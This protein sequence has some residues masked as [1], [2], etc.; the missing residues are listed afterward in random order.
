MAI[1]SDYWHSIADA[2]IHEVGVANCV[3]GGNNDLL[4]FG[5]FV[6]KV[7]I[8]DGIIPVNPAAFSFKLNK[9]LEHKLG[10]DYWFKQKWNNSEW[11]YYTIP[12]RNSHTPGLSRP[13]DIPISPQWQG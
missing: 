13:L 6:P 5:V 7:D 10:L 9:R 2:K 8:L 4:N 1:H 11:C 12:H 3:Y